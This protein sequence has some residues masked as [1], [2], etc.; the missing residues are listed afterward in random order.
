M[1]ITGVPATPTT[2]NPVTVKLF[3]SKSESFVR[4]EPLKVVPCDPVTI[5]SAAK[6]AS[7]TGVITI[8]NL[9]VSEPPFPS[10]IV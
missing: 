10:E 3:P 2:V 8:D 6:G 9:A 7:L 4:T 5:S 1:P